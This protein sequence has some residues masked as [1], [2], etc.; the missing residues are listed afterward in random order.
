M[1]WE[2]FVE[3]TISAFKYLLGVGMVASAFTTAFGPL[4]PVAGSLGWIYSS[5]FALIMF[6]LFFLVAGVM[7]LYGKVTKSKKF[8]G[9]GLMLTYLSFLF[10]T[11]LNAL[12]F[13]ITA[14][15]VWSNAIFVVVVG[16]LWLRWRFK[17]AYI[18]PNHFRPE[19]ENIKETERQKT[20]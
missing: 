2:L 8:T 3:N 10:A 20:L 1:K 17:T 7:L 15:N 5:R 12:A 16:I 18:N 9:W 19:I 14:S 11:L 6:G 13:G 4:E